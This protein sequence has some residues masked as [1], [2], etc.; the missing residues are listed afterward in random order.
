ML[1]LLKYTYITE[2]RKM[3]AI[4]DM[5]IPAARLY[6]C[7]GCP[8]L[9]S[10]SFMTSSMNSSLKSNKR[11]DMINTL[12]QNPINSLSKNLVLPVYVYLQMTD[13]K[14]IEKR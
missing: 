2:T 1:L 6:L 10:I 9:S 3:V 13:T 11:N 5:T 8:S 14:T 12:L 7:Q 4:R